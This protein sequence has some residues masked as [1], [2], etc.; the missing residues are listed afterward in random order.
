MSL[1]QEFAKVTQALE[2]AG[3]RYVLVG[4]LALAFHTQPRLTQDIDILTTPDQITL[5]YQTLESVGY[6]ES[7]KP[8]SFKAG[9]LTLHRLMRIEGEEH[10]IIDILN[11]SGARTN[12]IIENAMVDQVE[13]VPIRVARKEDLIY[14]K[15]LRNSTQDRADIERLQNDE[16]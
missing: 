13:S 9:N 12:D 16:A 7:T 1:Y 15:S 8:W 11:G 5:I 10:Y 4:G 3:V 14:L 6:F 2:A